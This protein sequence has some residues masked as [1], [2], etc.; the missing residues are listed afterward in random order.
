MLAVI[1]K[2]QRPGVLGGGSLL[3]LHVSLIACGY[4]EGHCAAPD[5]HLEATSGQGSRINHP[6]RACGDCTPIVGVLTCV[7]YVPRQRAS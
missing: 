3:L 6:A 4:C 1:R 2:P 5:I 7:W